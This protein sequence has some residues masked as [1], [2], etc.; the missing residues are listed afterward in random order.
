MKKSLLLLSGVVLLVLAVPGFSAGRIEPISAAPGFELTDFSG[1][2][3]VLSKLPAGGLPARIA[4]AGKSAFII[5]NTLYLF[6][7]AKEKVAGL[8]TPDQGRGLF[9]EKIDPF[10]GKKAVYGNN[11]GTEELLSLRPD[12]V[13]MKDFQ[14]PALEKPL[15]AI[16]VPLLALN[17]ENPDSFYKE[18]LTLG[19]LFGNEERA[20]SIVAWY[21]NKMAGIEKAVASSGA[22]TLP[23]VLLLYYSVKDGITTFSVPP[24]TWIQTDMVRKGG[25]D[26]VWKGMKLENQ[27]TKVG[28]E[29]IAAWDPEVVLLVS[30]REPAEVITEVMKKDAV[31][32][33]ISAVKNGM[34]Y[35]F[36]GDFHSWDQPDPR[37]ILGYIWVSEVLK[38]RGKPVTLE[39]MEQPVREFYSFAY[40]MGTEAFNAV[41][42]PKLTGLSN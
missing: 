30:Y 33:S 20:Q 18:V 39:F 13:V 5:V 6:E 25:G 4:Q 21:R 17:L 37:W 41:I 36:P 19:R 31:W 14:A 32:Q 3:I 9:V 40:G 11:V 23:R 22:A 12:V 10:F 8:S 16:G 28:L 26:P 29:Q 1:K 15:A 35:P 42:S 7:E 34:L 24:L 2:K 38:N 27:W